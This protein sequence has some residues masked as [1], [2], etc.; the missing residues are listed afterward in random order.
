M[1]SEE[2]RL[3]LTKVDASWA[4]P[5]IRYSIRISADMSWKAYVYGSE[6]P[7]VSSVVT[8]TPSVLSTVEA[9]RCLL[10]CLDKAC[11]CEGNRD[12]KFEELQSLRGFRGTSSKCIVNV[13]WILLS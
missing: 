10:L 5:D 7:S 9:V 8:H 12:G 4:T 13:M 6:I 3:V 2:E 1:T 11:I